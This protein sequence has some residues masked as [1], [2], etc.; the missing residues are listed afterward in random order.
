[1][2]KSTSSAV[3]GRLFQAV[4]QVYG[5]KIQGINMNKVHHVMS[6]PR[7]KLSQL[8]VQSGLYR[9]IGVAS[10]NLPR[11]EFMFA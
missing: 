11:Q 8:S 10:G 2:A 9:L 3:F 6:K 1:M 5:K 4:I 7:H